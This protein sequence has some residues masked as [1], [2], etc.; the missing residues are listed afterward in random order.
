MNY[1]YKHF[2]YKPKMTAMVFNVTVE[3]KIINT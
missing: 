1:R 3:I 2:S